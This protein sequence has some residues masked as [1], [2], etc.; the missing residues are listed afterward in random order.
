MHVSSFQAPRS[1]ICQLLLTH[2]RPAYVTPRSKPQ[3]TPRNVADPYVATGAT[4]NIT[5]R[6]IPPANAPLENFKVFTE[7][8]FKD[9]MDKCAGYL[10]CKGVVYGANLTDMVADGKP[11][12]NCLLKNGTWD[13][14]RPP[15]K[16]WMASGA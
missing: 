2:C 10:H 5:C 13:A 1:H 4:F 6:R 11:G 14:S 7:Y 16:F 8:T 3:A 9:C 12:G 15:G